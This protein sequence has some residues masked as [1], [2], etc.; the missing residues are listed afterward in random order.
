MARWLDKFP[1]TDAQQLRT[2]AGQVT[3]EGSLNGEFVINKS[4]TSSQDVGLSNSDAPS[5]LVINSGATFNNIGYTIYAANIDVYGVLETSSIDM[6]DSIFIREGGLLNMSNDDNTIATSLLSLEDGSTFDIGSKTQTISRFTANENSTIKLAISSDGA[7]AGYINVSGTANINSGTILNVVIP[8]GVSLE[9]QYTIVTGAGDTDLSS[10]PNLTIKINGRSAPTFGIY[11]LST[12]TDEENL[13][14]VVEDISA[15]SLSPAEVSFTPNNSTARSVAGA[16]NS[17]FSLSGKLSDFDTGLSSMNNS[18]QEVALKSAAAQSDN[19]LQKGMFNAALASA[20]AVENHLDAVSGMN[21]TSNTA[22][23]ISSGDHKTKTISS[24]AQAFGVNAKQGNFGGLDGYKSN[25]MGFAVGYDKLLDSDKNF[26]GGDATRLGV[27]LS[28]ANTNIKGTTGGKKTN[29]D[30]YQVNAYSSHN[31]GKH[32]F[33][34]NILGVAFSSYDSRRNI[35]IINSYATSSYN[36]N[37]I[38]AKI[39][40][41]YNQNLNN[42]FTL[43]PEVMINYV[44]NTINGH[45][46]TGAGNMSL[47]TNKSNSDFLEG[48][49]GLALGHKTITANK[50]ILLSTIRASYGYDFIGDKQTTV[51]NFQDQTSSFSNQISKMNRNSIKLGA[52]LDIIN[53][54]DISLKLDYT[55]E[56]KTSYNS[57]T[58]LIKAKYEF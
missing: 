23:G 42:N 47:H 21:F 2:L 53:I 17:I 55:Y 1:G 34:D 5:S 4:Y 32:F 26:L 8:K 41:G 25:T 37:S 29:V 19:S 54:N 31:Y 27:A 20:T 46:E 38:V 33:L 52:S 7:T 45:S 57:H 40:A 22:L 48:R 50:T 35:D 9:D 18:Q 6:D 11:S 28:Y 10:L 13:F 3:G 58:G 51:S 16:I 15:S 49:A 43:T 44:H 14:L 24:W 30:T 56:H 12:S 39:K 36:G